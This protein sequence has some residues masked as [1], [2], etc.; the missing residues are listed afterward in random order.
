MDLIGNSIF[1]ESLDRYKV[2]S[3]EKTML[4]EINALTLATELYVKMIDMIKYVKYIDK[5]LITP[6]RFTYY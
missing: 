6:K 4:L 3:E 1:S 5:M 2:Y